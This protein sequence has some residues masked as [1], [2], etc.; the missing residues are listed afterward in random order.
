MKELE[1]QYQQSRYEAQRKAQEQEAS[2]SKQLSSQVS[3]F[4]QTET[5]LR[6][7]L[8]IYVEKFKQ[9]SNEFRDSVIRQQWQWQATAQSADDEAMT[10]RKTESSSTGWTPGWIP[11]PPTSMAVLEKALLDSYDSDDSD[12]GQGVPLPKTAAHDTP[13]TVPNFGPQDLFGGDAVEKEEPKAYTTKFAVAVEI[14]PNGERRVRDVFTNT[15]TTSSVSLGPHTQSHNTKA[16][17]LNELRGMPDLPP[18]LSAMLPPP[19]PAKHRKKAKGPN[20]T[21]TKI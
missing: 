6:S 20:T 1:V 21:N 15:T 12:E 2:K 16:R 18:R 7:Q 5:E 4:S 14:G 9:V 11:P 8:N 19:V 10:P 13:Y 17:I 3:T